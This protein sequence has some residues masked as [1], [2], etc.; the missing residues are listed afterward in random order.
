LTFFV[1]WGEWPRGPST[2]PWPYWIFTWPVFGVLELRNLSDPDGMSS[3]IILLTRTCLILQLYT[4]RKESIFKHRLD[5]G[6]AS[7]K[8]SPWASTGCVVMRCLGFSDQISWNLRWSILD[9][10]R[11]LNCYPPFLLCS[12]RSKR[13]E[14]VWLNPQLFISCSIETSWRPRNHVSDKSG[15]NFRADT[16]RS[17]Q[18]H[19]TKCERKLFSPMSSCPENLT[20]DP[21]SNLR[22]FWPRNISYNSSPSSLVLS[23]WSIKFGT[24]CESVEDLA[25]QSCHLV[26]SEANHEVKVTKLRHGRHFSNVLNI[27]KILKCIRNFA[28]S[29]LEKLNLGLQ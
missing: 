22:C 7:V 24:S 20:E 21:V 29:S 5:T 1:D 12:C 27:L 19:E 14:E 16:Q 11:Y 8:Q 17:L 4:T 23:P 6:L 28:S 10:I 9:I 25:T 13:H 18:F 26:I 15:E 3:Y 2:D